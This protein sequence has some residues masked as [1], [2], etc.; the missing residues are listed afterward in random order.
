[1]ECPKGASC[2]GP[3]TQDGIKARFG[4]WRESK[5]SKAFFRCLKPSACLGAPNPNLETQFPD[6]RKDNNESCQL[7]TYKPSRLCAACQA[8]Y[9]RGNGDGSC[10]RCTNGFWNAVEFVVAVVV[11]TLFLLFLV[12]VTVFKPRVVRL[13]DGIKKIG[14]SYLQLATLAMHVDVPWTEEL[15]NLFSWQSYSS[16]VSE[17]VFSVDCL[18]G[19]SAF[20]AFRL[21]F[22]ATMVSPL[23]IVACSYLDTG[24]PRITFSILRNRNFAVVF[25]VSIC[26]QQGGD[27]VH[28]HSAW[29]SIVLGI[30]S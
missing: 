30:G 16:N 17:A 3:I 8:G 12:R 29:R 4:W 22:V 18:F 6:A 2:A 7:K 1:M 13:S 19:W 25:G 23:V 21:K 10:N 5:S 26:C 11:G 15:Q 20:D 9:A 27:F 28:L 24:C 14:L